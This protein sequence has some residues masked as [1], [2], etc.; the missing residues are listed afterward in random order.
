VSRRELAGLAAAAC[1]ACCAGPILAAVGGI[2]A[3]GLLGSIAFGVAALVVPA[4]VIG[5][6]LTARARVRHRAS[7]RS[8]PVE[9]GPTHAGDRSCRG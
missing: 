8:Q 3:L 7:V 4:G 1:V 6:V 2:A 9:L 5:A